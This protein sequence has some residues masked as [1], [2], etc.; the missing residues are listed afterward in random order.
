VERFNMIVD[1]IRKS[2][3]TAVHSFTVF[4]QDLNY[5]N[6]LFGGKVMAEMDIAGVKVV[7][8]ALYGT[9]ADGCV[10]ASVDRIDFKKPAFLGDLITM[11]SEIK[12]IGK[13]SLQVRITV[14]RES[15]LGE[16]DDICAANFTFV[17][18]KNKKPF[19][20]GLS[21]EILEPVED[22]QEVLSDNKV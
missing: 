4:P 6:S 11:V 10:T 2:K 21:F 7:R 14:T 3:L 13:S 16:I 12:A 19:Q 22:E 15:I 20:H 17:A 8:R 1:K 9:G 18:M 5:V